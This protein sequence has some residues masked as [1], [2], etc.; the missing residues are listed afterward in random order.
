MI[1][2]ASDAVLVGRENVVSQLVVLRLGDGSFEHGFPVTLQIG[3]ET[4]RPS[5][6]VSGYLP[7]APELPF[8]Y[9][10]WK[11]SY[12]KLGNPSRIS[13]K[14]IASMDLPQ[15]RIQ[16]YGEAQHLRTEFSHWLQ[17]DSFRVIRE[18]LLERLSTSSYIRVL[19]QTRNLQ[20]QRLP[21]HLWDF[22]ERYPKAEL[23]F[24]APAYERAGQLTTH[25]ETVKIL[26]VLGNSQGINVQADRE[27][28][29]QLDGADVHF[30]VEPHRR[31]LTDQFWRQP[32]DILFF[33]GHSS[34]QVDETGWIEINPNERLS[35]AQLKFALRKAV[36]RGLRLAIFNSC[37]GLGLAQNL[38]DLHIPQ[39]VVMREPVPDQIAQEFLKYFLEAF[40]YG[41][42]F[43]LSIREARERLEGWEDEFPCATWLPTIFQNPAEIPPTWQELRQPRQRSGGIAPT[44]DSPTSP[45]RSEDRAKTDSTS[46]PTHAA[47]VEQPAID[48]VLTVNPAFLER[49]QQD[50]SR[51]IGPIA[52]FIVKD[53]LAREPQISPQQ[54][55]QVLASKISDAEQ[56]EQFQQGLK[57][58]LKALPAKPQLSQS[59][60]PLSMRNLGLETAP[61]S[62]LETCQ[63]V[64]ESQIVLGLNPEF[65]QTC[66]QELA[67]YIGPIAQHILATTKAQQ[68]QATPQEFVAALAAKIPDPRQA[69]AFQ[70]SLLSA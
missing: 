54:L 67:R 20:L 30:L 38:A 19:L 41:E 59:P 47:A 43:Y 37:D 4:A 42:S 60:Q 64:A 24:S 40:A 70:R 49:C 28:L 35:I 32:W 25:Q 57:I 21:W 53:T 56:A 29:E 12:E 58:L 17:A 13:V 16:C 39:I 23:A 3:E 65:L 52:N 66:Q 68:A 36:E 10:R 14:R 5:T 48:L 51:Y 15:R 46:I 18:K 61:M 2:K 50:L 26:A 62:D 34:T 33:A 27:L 11:A 9:E 22:F 55:I 69:E 6:E 63:G 1:G 45:I 7:P 31:D 8:A 44:L